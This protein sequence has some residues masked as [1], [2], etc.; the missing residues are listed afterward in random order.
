[1][2]FFVRPSKSPKDQA[3]MLG[4]EVL[5]ALGD[6]AK[7]AFLAKVLDCKDHEVRVHPRLID[8]L[9]KIQRLFLFWINPEAGRTDNININHI[10][11]LHD[12]AQVPISWIF[13]VMRKVQAKARELK[14]HECFF[15]H[16]DDFLQGIIQ[17]QEKLFIL[18]Q[19]R[20]QEEQHYWQSIFNTLTEGA[21]IFDLDGALYDV[22]DAYCQITGYTREELF[23]KGW[24]EL[25]PSEYRDEDQKRLPDSMAGKV[26][27][28]EKAYIHKDGHRVP[29]LVSYRLLK[30]RPEWQE[31]RLI[32]TCVDLTEAKSKERRLIR[33][34]A[35]LEASDGKIMI[36]DQKG[37]IVYA[38][39]AA[40]KLFSDRAHEVRKRLPNFDPEKL[41]GSSYDLYHRDPAATRSIIEHLQ[42]AHRATL[43]F[44]DCTFAFIAVPIQMDGQKLGTVVEWRDITEEISIEQ[45]VQVLIEHI[46]AGDFSQRIGAKIGDIAKRMANAINLLMD[47]SAGMTQYAKACLEHLAQAMLIHDITPKEG[48]A[49]AI[50]AT[51]NQCVDNLQS[52]IGTV[53]RAAQ[54]LMASSKELTQGQMVLSDRASKEAAS[55][56]EISANIEEISSAVSESAKNAQETQAITEEILKLLNTS[57]NAINDVVEVIFGAAKAA[58]ETTQIAKL[59]EE[60][61]FTTN[62]LSLNA[63]VEAARAGQHGRGF[64]VIAEEVRRL[65]LKVSEES[66]RAQEII[67]T[68]LDAIGKGE[69]GVQ[70]VAT[71]MDQIDG[72]SHTIAEHIQAI[73]RATQEQD[74]GL[75]Q[76]A[77]GINILDEGLAQNAAMAE[78]IHGTTIGLQEQAE[79]LVHTTQQFESD[80]DFTVLANGEDSFSKKQQNLDQY[81]GAPLGGRLKP[82]FKYS[83]GRRDETWE[84]F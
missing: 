21:C 36:A 6:P 38:N 75:K 7:T 53:S 40:K 50:Q 82:S 58:R 62:L 3:R 27:R 67:Q 35:A 12:R 83:D 17:A 47:E 31:D 33:L 26:V 61:A 25:T 42:G 79:R 45:E 9:N 8:I 73:A 65:A 52:L 69:S 84:A 59:I 23:Q 80:R 32:C 78:E 81:S 44:G 74:E 54:T 46:K 34:S 41:V 29:I 28:Y 14:L 64:A 56:E 4:E 72:K 71:V 30:R 10:A 49:K 11:E 16:S 24:L 5:V 20:F 37:V 76:I 63:S 48:A 22:N 1:M 57:T 55:L 15:E 39:P 77:Q 51:Y 68:L 70:Q 13:E 18:H 2:P 66:Q 43:A 60:I 19:E